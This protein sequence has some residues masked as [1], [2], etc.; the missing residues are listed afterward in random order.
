LREEIMAQPGKKTDLV[1]AWR[2][3]MIACSR[4]DQLIIQDTE[5]K[6]LY[7]HDGDGLTTLAVVH[8]DE[9]EESGFHKA[10]LDAHQD[11]LDQKK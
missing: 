8:R 1:G 11:F 6:L 9:F 3:A 10:V 4:G 2:N 7:S 5:G